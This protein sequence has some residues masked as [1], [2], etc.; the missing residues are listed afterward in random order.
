M[1]TPKSS[2]ETVE[3][4]G[5]LDAGLDAMDV[6]TGESWSLRELMMQGGLLR[7]LIR[8]AG[9]RFHL[10]EEDRA[11][12][13]DPAGRSARRLAERGQHGTKSGQCRWPSIRERS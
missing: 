8:H 9:P 1:T 12:E 6:L 10:G 13:A 11:N 4:T 3:P 2:V 7:Q 5:M